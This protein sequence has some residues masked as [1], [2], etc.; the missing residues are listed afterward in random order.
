[1]EKS[2]YNHAEARVRP[3]KTN[4]KLERKGKQFNTSWQGKRDT[5]SG[6]KA[7]TIPYEKAPPK[8]QPAVARNEDRISPTNVRET[9]AA[10]SQTGG[11]PKRKEK[12]YCVLCYGGD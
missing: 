7:V 6:I 9:F 3:E 8:K 2:F 12:A 5:L 10:M 11:S 4:Q 1:V